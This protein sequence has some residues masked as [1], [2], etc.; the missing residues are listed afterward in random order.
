MGRPTNVKIKLD[1]TQGK[2]L[3]ATWEWDVAHTDSFNVIWWYADE[4][5][6][7][8]QNGPRIGCC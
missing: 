1:T 8:P 6:G 3:V 5:E 7:I 4:H 2:T